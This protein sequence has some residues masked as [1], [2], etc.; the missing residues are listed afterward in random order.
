MRNSILVLF[1][2][3]L[4]FTATWAQN[5]RPKLQLL[6]RSQYA[7]RI[8]LIPY[9]GRPV[10]WKLPRMIARV[11][12][13]EIIYP[14]RELLGDL[15]HPPDADRVIE[16]AK[17]QNFD[18]LNG[19]IVSLDALAGWTGETTPGQSKSRLEFIH[20]MRQRKSDLPIYGFTKK[21]RD[22]ISGFVF[23]DLLIDPDNNE[24]AYLMVARFL[25]RTYQRQT[26]ITPIAST[27]YPP[28]VLKAINRKIDAIGGQL[29]TSGKV[30]LL[31]FLYV[32]NTD[33]VK[34][35]K[36][37]EAL[38]KA[39]ASGYYVALADVSGNPEPLIAALRERKQLDM[40]HAYAAA[41]DPDIAIGKALAQVSARLVAAKVLRPML[42]I[43]Q[44]H[45]GERAQVEL[46]MTRYLEDWGYPAKIRANLETH[47]REQ[48]KADPGNLGNTA[49][50]AEA[51]LN[52]EVRLLADEIFRT[53]F[54][55]NVH[56][57]MLKDGTRADFQVEML[58]RCK[59]RLPFQRTNEI[60]LDVG[61]HIPMLV[62]INPYP[63]RR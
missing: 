63:A 47:I 50:S 5:K 38:V 44:L 60:E 21:A 19:V 25:H 35:A 8:L 18:Q 62:G 15:T 12:D 48:L 17:K 52:T 43:D 32:P 46:M 20:W 57:V 33:E 16:W 4:F 37:F 3:P 24:A 40:L 51:V 6:E 28:A 58:Q 29:V 23:D 56:S 1:C 61:I 31:L 14:P 39:I 7:G 41:S 45:R 2:L 30:E 55:Y 11:A 34:T 10:S 49:E 26:K 54:R 42:E 13:Y 59:A 22:E 53:Q 27:E 36:F 9:D